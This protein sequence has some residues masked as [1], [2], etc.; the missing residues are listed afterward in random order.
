MNEATKE[1]PKAIVMGQHVSRKSLILICTLPNCFVC[2]IGL[3]HYCECSTTTGLSCSI[4][5]GERSK[6]SEMQSFL[7]Q[8]ML[9]VS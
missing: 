1:H 7:L 3:R 8:D 9:L 5:T 4:N 6:T 2:F